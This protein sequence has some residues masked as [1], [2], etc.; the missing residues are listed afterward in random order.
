MTLAEDDLDSKA[1]TERIL[2]VKRIHED[3]L[4]SKA[5]VVGV[6]IGFRQKDGQPTESLALVVM[7]SSKVPQRTLSPEDQIPVSLDGIAVDVQEIGEI[8][9]L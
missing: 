1:E 5:N 6:A 9:A 4:L 2:V 7:V 8:S 3:D